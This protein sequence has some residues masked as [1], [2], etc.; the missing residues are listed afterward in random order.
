MG[1]Q[2]MVAPWLVKAMQ[3][4]NNDSLA[5]KDAYTAQVH[6]PGRVLQSI[7]HWAF[8]SLP[9]EILVGIEV[10]HNKPHVLE[11]EQ[12]YLSEQQR[13]NL[14]AGQGFQIAEAKVVNRGDSYSVHHLPEEWTDEIFGAERGPR[15]G[16]FTHWLHTHPNCVAIP[17]GADADAAQSTDGIDMILGIGFT[18][19]GF[20]PWFEDVEGQ[21]RILDGKKEVILGM[22]PTGHAIH[23]LEMIGFHK[24][25]LGINV[26]FIDE[27]GRDY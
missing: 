11:V 14:F 12:K 13:F 5:N 20:N 26:I 19:E 23:I 24:S 17:S 1:G 10:D 8:Q 25:G 7:L 22:A 21:R 4:Y 9:D 18:P 15:A 3:R 16:R 27:N 6:M 2:F